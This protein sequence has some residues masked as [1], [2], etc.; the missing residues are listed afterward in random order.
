ML[1]QH[2]PCEEGTLAPRTGREVL[3]NVTICSPD[4]NRDHAVSVL[5]VRERDYDGGAGTRPRLSP[6][7]G[8]PG[9]ENTWLE[10]VQKKKKPEMQSPSP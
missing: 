6:T 7:S 4:D 10:F 2:R 9:P 1:S 5:V 8:E 3:L